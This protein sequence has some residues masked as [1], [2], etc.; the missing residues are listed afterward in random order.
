MYRYASHFYI[1]GNVSGKYPSSLLDLQ[2]PKLAV[3]IRF[4]APT[5]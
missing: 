1:A 5:F 3:A 4:I 2:K